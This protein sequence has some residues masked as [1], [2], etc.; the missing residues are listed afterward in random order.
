MRP[1][2][3]MG[4]ALRDLYENSWRFVPA[5]A[6]LGLVL[7]AVG[8]SGSRCPSRSSR[9]CWP[10]RW[11]RGSCTWPSRS[12]AP[13][14]SC[15]RDA[16]DGLLAALAARA[17]AGRLRRP[18]GCCCA[19]SPCA[20]TPQLSLGWPLAFLT[21]YLVVMVGFY[22]VLVWTLAIAEPGAAAARRRRGARPRSSPRGPA[23]TLLLGLAL[24][25]VNL[26]GIAAALMPFLTLTVAYSFLAVAR[27][28]LP[29]PA[30]E[31]PA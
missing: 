25:L 29:R 19:P 6:A 4:L 30:P 28:A 7:V 13:A 8:W 23:Q 5:N 18:S 16:L 3:A 1:D 15:S 12:C 20:S 9:W 10:G 2:E 27:F 17:R 26:V 21:L 14:T 31:E 22:Q 11:P 24:L